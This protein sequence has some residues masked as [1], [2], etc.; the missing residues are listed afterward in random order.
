MAEL[1]S[2]QTGAIHEA[3]VV[4]VGGG[5]AGAC[6]ANILGR[7]GVRI[8]LI[9]L[10]AVHPPEF[11]AEKIAGQQ[12]ECLRRNGLF[13]GL[14]KVATPVGTIL[15][16]RAGRVV[17]EP[18]ST[19][20]GALYA[21]M[22]GALRA[23][24]PAS[25]G[26]IAGRAADIATSDDMQRVT[27]SDGTQIDARLVILATGLGD[28]LRKKIGV[29][30]RVV[31]DAHSVG[32]GFTLA[33]APGQPFRFAG[34]CYY[35]SS[36]VTRIDYISVFPVG[37]VMRANLFAYRDHRDSWIRALRASPRATLY[38]AMPGARR[39]LGD[40]E[41]SGKVE[42]RVN[43]LYE[44]ENYV[45]G[46][47]VLIGDAFKT[48]CPAVGMGLSRLLTD[49]ERLCNAYAP[50][51]L[52]TPGMSASKIASFYADAEKRACD[53]ASDHASEYRRASTLGEGL[54]WEAH[55]RQHYFRRRL[56]N[57]LRQI[58]PRPR[59]LSPAV[60]PG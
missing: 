1:S 29:G 40:F 42:L 28:A 21:D 25:V 44:A 26:F 35:G 47:V 19:E 32:V 12:I 17:D 56:R 16:A 15:N 10:H 36:P 37:D 20:Y 50:Q 45:K 5:F 31:R 58:A 38:A 24:L 7:K 60:Q 18:G 6:A 54:R 27:L 59:P 48:S 2:A 30:R 57:W 22:I 52:A 8:A 33:P 14:A 51:W 46:G 3:D 39:F 53:A 4:I 43:D 34:L 9:D 41:V 49:V 23:Q 13:E 11:R 55:R